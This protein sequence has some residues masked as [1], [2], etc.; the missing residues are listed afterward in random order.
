MHLNGAPMPPDRDSGR[1]GGAAAPARGRQLRRSRRRSSPAR[2]WPTASWIYMLRVPSGRAL[3]L[4]QRRREARF[5]VPARALRFR[6][7][8]A[9]GH[10]AGGP[11]RAE[12]GRAGARSAAA[13]ATARVSARARRYGGRE[14]SV[15]LGIS[16]AYGWIMVSPF[17]ARHRHRVRWMTAIGL[18]GSCAA[19]GILGGARTGRPGAALPAS[20]AVW[21]SPWRSSPPAGGL[22]PGPLVGV[23]RPRALGAAGGWALRRAAAYLERRCVSPSDS[24]FSSS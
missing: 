11:S 21:S 16:P 24:E 14:R 4:S 17:Q 12:R 7:W 15:E 19:A 20:R 13:S 9:D 10:L 6:F 18:A 1:L 22:P 8:S 5:A 3:T 23:A 2:R